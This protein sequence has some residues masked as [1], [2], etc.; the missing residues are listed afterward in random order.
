MHYYQQEN[1]QMRTSPPDP[2]GPARR[3]RA[4]QCL[5]LLGSLAIVLPPALADPTPATILVGG[6]IVP[7]QVKPFVGPDGQVEAPVDAVQLL[8]AKFAPNS[9]GT[10]SVTSAGGRRF[11]VPYTMV[12]GRYCVPF[13]KV[14][15]ALGGTADWQPTTAT[16]TVR[17]RLQMVRQDNGA[18][19]V[20]TSYPV[21]YSVKRIDGPE[22]LHVD[23]YGLDLATTPANIPTSGSSVTHIRSGQINPQTVRITIDLKRGMPFRV[24]SGIQ[25]SLV[26]VALGE[27]G[28]ASPAPVSAPPVVSPPV[29]HLPTNPAQVTITAV[30]YKV[31]SAALTQIRITTT[32]PAKYRTEALNDPNRLAFDLA[33]AVL[34][35]NVRT[36]Q[37]VDN[38]VVKAI[39]IGKVFTEHTAFGRIVLDLSRMV[40]FS[41]DS[42]TNAG[43]MT[44]LINVMTSGSDTAAAPPVVSQPGPAGGLLPAPVTASLAGKL[45]VIDPGHGGR[46]T[47]AIDGFRTRQVYEKDIALAIGRRVRD[48][49][50]QNGATVLMTRNSDVLPTVESRP[51]FANAHHADYF[52]SIH[53]DS[54]EVQNARSG[55]AVYFHGASGMCRLMAADIGRRIS[56][57]SGLPYNGVKSDM[58]QYGGRFVTGYGVLRTSAM[59]AVLVETGFMT[60][61]SDLAK[62]RDDA[63]QEKIAQGVVAGLRDFISDQV[64]SARSARGG[65][66]V[67]RRAY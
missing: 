51:L 23:L 57:V 56:Q 32:G 47:G 13:Q 24:V 58:I 5:F 16:L 9:D 28:P 66:G 48:V 6:R 17:A 41:V 46:D 50:T 44:Y 40:G 65:R 11:S 19:S 42:R 39:R 4:L 2:D 38:P 62:L 10:V 52:V 64:A 15:Q 18:L 27:S 49:L 20:Y 37:A 61:D 30:D 25:T 1:K 33:G 59:P 55:T 63:T 67:P 22:R 36:T 45:I 35:R 60:S 3:S 8:G 34:D 26:R 43:G 12:Q 21:Y 29:A 53:C 7:F 14:A 54:A 31:V